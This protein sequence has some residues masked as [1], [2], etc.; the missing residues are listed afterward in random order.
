MI[1]S[2][3]ETKVSLELIAFLSKV[4]NMGLMDGKIIGH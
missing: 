3:F 2:L 4:L 1:M